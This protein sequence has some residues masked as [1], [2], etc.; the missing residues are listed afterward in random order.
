VVGA[1]AFAQSVLL[2]SLTRARATLGTVVTA[3]GLSARSAADRFGF[4]SCSTSVDAVWNDGRCNAVVISTRHDS[5]SRLV[6]AAL[7]AGKAVFV[8]KPLCITEPELER[9]VDVVHR[10]RASGASPFVMVGFNRRFSPSVQTVRA[11]MAGPVSIVYRVNAG[12]VPQS[13]WIVHPEEGGGRIVGEACHF[14]DLCAHLAGAPVVEVSATRA[15]AAPDDVMV[16]LRM[17][18]GS[19]ATIAYLSDG[20]RASGKERIELFGGGRSG[21]IDDFRRARV[22]GAG[23]IVRHGGWLARPDKGHKAEIAAFVAG[24]DSGGVSP[25]SFESAVNTTRAT[26]AIVRSLESGGAIRIP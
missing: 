16:N 4:E 8:E 23:R 15:G 12:T 2:P 7:E 24:V 21:T 19:A 26:F 11:A 14:V 1:G 6:I 13:S 3:T 5:H 22:S 18:N 17:A 20:D 25:V 10:L 9:I